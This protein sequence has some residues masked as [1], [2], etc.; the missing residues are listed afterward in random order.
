MKWVDTFLARLD[1]AVEWK[2][3]GKLSWRYVPDE[4]WLLV[5]PAALEMVGGSADGES[6]YPFFTLHVSH[7]IEVFDD[8]PEMMW[9][10]MQNEFSVEG[11]IDGDEAWVTI[12]REPFDDDEPEDIV[13]P[14]GGIRKKKPPK[15]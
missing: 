13:D 12:S 9:D 2:S 11:T 3:P 10:T 4:D 5:A 14:L 7:L 8:V 1:E 15:R 6:V